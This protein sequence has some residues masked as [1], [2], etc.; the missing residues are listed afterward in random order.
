MVSFNPLPSLCVGITPSILLIGEK[1]LGPE[2]CS[3]QLGGWRRMEGRSADS[4][5]LLL[6]HPWVSDGYPRLLSLLVPTP[7]SGA[8]ACFPRSCLCAGDT[9]PDIC[10]KDAAIPETLACCRGLAF[11]F[12]ARISPEV[13][14]NGA[15]SQIPREGLLSS[16]QGWALSQINPTYHL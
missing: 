10:P 9:F 16:V 6:Q 1:N 11:T 4:G 3:M 14:K 5:S 8:L 2:A 12:L 7:G 13:V 15:Q